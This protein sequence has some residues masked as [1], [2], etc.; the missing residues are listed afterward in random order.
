MSTLISQGGF[1]CIYY[2]GLKCSGD[3]SNDKEYVSKLQKKD[4][5]AMF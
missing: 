3:K 4:F 5:N 2:P 1:G